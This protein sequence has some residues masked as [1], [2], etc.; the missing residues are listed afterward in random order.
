MVSDPA[1]VRVPP[2]ATVTALLSPMA[3]PPLAIR[4]PA[5]TLVA[6]V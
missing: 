6:P 5:L 4:L 3:E 2:L 1:R